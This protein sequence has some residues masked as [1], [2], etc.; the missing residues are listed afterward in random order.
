MSVSLC[1]CFFLFVCLFASTSPELHF[2]R[3]SPIF[4]HVT[5]AVARSSYGGVA[6]CSVLPTDVMSARSGPYG[7]HV[8]TVQRVT[9]SCAG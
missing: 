8:N 4:V 1:V 7:P 6:I 2:V 3:P 9:S 5:T